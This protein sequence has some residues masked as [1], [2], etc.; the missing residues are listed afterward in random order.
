MRPRVHGKMMC[1][2]T[3]SSL[4]GRG[5]C[6]T[7]RTRTRRPSWHTTRK[8]ARWLHPRLD[9]LRVRA[10]RDRDVAVH[11]CFRSS[12]GS[13]GGAGCPQRARGR[14][15]ERMGG[16]Q[17]DGSTPGCILSALPLT[18]LGQHG[19]PVLSL[20]SWLRRWRGLSERARGRAG[21]TSNLHQK[22]AVASEVQ[23]G[24]WSRGAGHRVR[25]CRA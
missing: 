18:A 17:R 21:E 24:H 12:V 2:K 20:V 23:T 19:P 15:G 13:G 10:D 9:S 22:A 7:C 5:R 25:R 14:A 16:R 11:Q 4:S 3:R 1:K 6:R 8:T